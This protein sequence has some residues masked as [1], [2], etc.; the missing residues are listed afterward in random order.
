M[1]DILLAMVL[2][3]VVGGGTVLSLAILILR[4]RRF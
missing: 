4:Q 3:A 1:S 2:G